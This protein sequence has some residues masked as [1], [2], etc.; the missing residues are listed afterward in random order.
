MF[1]GQAS[2]PDYPVGGK[3]SDG[4]YPD[5]KFQHANWGKGFFQYF[6]TITAEDDAFGRSVFNIACAVIGVE[7]GKIYSPYNHQAI[8][9]GSGLTYT[10]KDSGY[11][12]SRFICRIVDSK[13]QILLCAVVGAESGESCTAPKI[14]D[15]IQYLGLV[16]VSQ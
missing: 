5:G 6:E 13:K 15:P 12:R 1:I 16:K 2:L 8:I 7:S 4:Y 9:S 3:E 14:S 10:R 11:C